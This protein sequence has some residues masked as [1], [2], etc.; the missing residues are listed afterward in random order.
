MMN[1]IPGFITGFREGLEA[2]LVAVVIIRYLD[3]IKQ[4]VLKKSL[5]WGIGLGILFSL[6]IGLILYLISMAIGQS[7]FTK[8]WESLSS[9]LALLL[10]TTFIIWMI[11]NGPHMVRDIE[12]KT[13]SHLSAKGIATVGAIMVAREGTEIAVF[14]FAGNYSAI[15]IILG[16]I[17]ALIA[18][19][20]VYYSLLKVNLKTLFNLTLIYLI[21]QAGF[22]FGYGIHEGLSA[23]KNLGYISESSIFL[24]KT[25]DLSKT[26]LN[27][28]TGI[29]G[30]PLFILFGW[31]S[32][33]EWIQF[34]VHYGYV[35]I[36]LIYYQRVRNMSD[37]E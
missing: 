37:K 12:T 17:L 11:K 20:L 4:Q 2:F 6:L 28:K 35:A 8:L 10:V 24:G 16:I 22:L 29:I 25:F 30:L 7:H 34:I 15:S 26:I 32:Q 5:Y 23:L 31:Y 36:L 18:V 1:F 9:I 27:S 3:K 14:T 19:I 13:Q 33:P 21:L